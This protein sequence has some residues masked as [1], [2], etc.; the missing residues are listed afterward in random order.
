MQRFVIMALMMLF[1]SPPPH[2]D[3]LLD[4]TATPSSC[5]Q[6]DPEMVRGA[7]SQNIKRKV[8]N[9]KNQISNKYTQK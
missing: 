5:S 2:K 3:E 8:T 7:K 4:T 1:S 6:V 9:E